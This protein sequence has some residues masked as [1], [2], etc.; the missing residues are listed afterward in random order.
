MKQRSKIVRDTGQ[1]FRF[2]HPRLS[3]GG[4]CIQ[5]GQLFGIGVYKINV[6]LMTEIG[7]V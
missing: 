6:V 5:A 4:L 3:L 2:S 1:I 7:V